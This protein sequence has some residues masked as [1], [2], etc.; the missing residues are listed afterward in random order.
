MAEPIAALIVRILADT[1][2][3]VT[4]VKN[5]AGQLDG[6]ESKVGQF[7]KRLAGVFTV[8]A[9]IGFS[10]QIL[11]EADAID[12][13]AKR[14]GT[15]AE[16]FQRFSYA[17]K[18]SGGDADGATAAIV[19][20]SEKLSSGDAGLLG[21]LRK[22]NIDLE[23]FKSMD[24]ID[25]F[26][27]LATAIANVT[28][29]TERL[30]L[31]LEALG[32]KGEKA[33]AAVDTEFKK[34]AD[35]APVYSEES[36][37][38]LDTLGDSFDDLWMR[39]KI[40]GAE[41]A[42]AVKDFF[43]FSKTQVIGPDGVPRFYSGDGSLPAA[44][45]APDKKIPGLGPGG[46]D[47]ND[48]KA[49]AVALADLSLEFTKVKNAQEATADAAKEANDEWKRQI[50]ILKMLSTT[51]I[52]AADAIGALMD[53]LGTSTKVDQFASRIINMA[54]QI[55]AVTT[56]TERLMEIINPGSTTL[57]GDDVDKK[58][59]DLRN[60]PRNFQT[61]GPEKGNL[62]DQALA[63]ESGYLNNYSLGLVANQMNKPTAAGAPMGNRSGFASVMNPTTVT[64]NAQ[65]AW[66]GDPDSQNRLARMIED[67]L[68]ARM[69]GT[70]A[71]TRR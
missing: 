40:G 16:E 12:A 31:R 28:D 47:P 10:K 4:G 15:S 51:T 20:L 52:P 45:G 5:V 62:T 6:L 53:R 3:M 44:P 32:T 64:V 59:F 9:I 37:R 35:N 26:M 60:D 29:P 23:R 50:D 48:P 30:E 34:L 14:L 43:D 67:A 18:Q 42:L 58:I 24:A 41:M 13:A 2:E 65:G 25:R 21:V 70:D 54:Q 8:G 71:F 39:I 1:S 27:T 63:L 61:S 55:A 19:K 69:K 68:T 36:I 33:L 46:V 49:L 56:E 17:I 22:L 11:E 66:L 7:G 38:A 57:A